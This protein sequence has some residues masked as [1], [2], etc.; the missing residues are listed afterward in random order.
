MPALIIAD[1]RLR[2]DKTGD[3]AIALIRDELNRDI[4]ALI[5]TGDTSP[6]RVREA[7]QSGTRLLHKPVTPNVLVAA[8]RELLQDDGLLSK[9]AS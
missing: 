2:E 9:A 1:Y 8:V 6:E 7:A 4:P 5:I 3:E